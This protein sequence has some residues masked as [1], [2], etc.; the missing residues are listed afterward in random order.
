MASLLA[1]RPP[2]TRRL[3]P[4]LK[5][6][7]RLT[8]EE[9]ERRWDLHPEIKRAEL[10][11]GEVFVDVSVSMTHGDAH[12]VVAMW[13]NVYRAAHPGC[14]VADN[15]T[16]ELPGDN[17][18]QP[19]ILIRRREGGTSMIGPRENLSG[20]PEFVLEVSAT[21]ASYDLHQKLRLYERSGVLEYAVW[22]LYEE[23]LDWFRLVDGQYVTVE[24]GPDGVIESSTFPGL[25]LNVKALLAGNLAGVLSALSSD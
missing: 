13:A 11:E 9:F 16:V 25:R 24:P 8:F 20:P 7:D 18:P 19:D 1:E 3:R 2:E 23:R 22:Q 17:A 6:G 12:G 14:Q 21:S 15:S 10:I 5:S 4:E